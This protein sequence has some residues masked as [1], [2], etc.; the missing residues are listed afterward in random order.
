MLGARPQNERVAARAAWLIAHQDATADEAAAEWRCRKS[1]IHQH[2]SA[3]RRRGLLPPAERATKYD[4][5]PVET[6]LLAEP[7]VLRQDL[8]RRLGVPCWLVCDVRRRLE[9]QGRIVLAPLPGAEA[10]SDD[11]PVRHPVLLS[12]LR[13][14]LKRGPLDLGQLAAWLSEEETVLLPAIGEGVRR[15]LFARRGRTITLLRRLGS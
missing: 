7:D 5:G 4:Q 1:V 6:A 8:A 2:R 15:G 11:E 14:L 12:R 13:E 9:E 10:Q 3:L